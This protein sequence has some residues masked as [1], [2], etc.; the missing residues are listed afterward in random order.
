M[1]ITRKLEEVGHAVDSMTTQEDLAGFLR[2]PENAQKFN[3][4]VEDIR[5]TLIDYQVR[6]PKCSLSSHLTSASDFFTTRHLQRELSVNSK[7]TPSQ[8][9]LLVVTCE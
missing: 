1:R 5:Y 2:N 8:S 3:S 9:G 6:T 4:L 7:F